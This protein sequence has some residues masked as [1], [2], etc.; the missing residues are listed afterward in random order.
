MAFYPGSELSNDATN[1][2]GPNPAAVTAMLKT[3][4][5]PRGDVVAGA[6]ALP[7]RLAKAAYYRARYGH[8]F[9][10]ALRADRMVAHAR[11]E[12]V[13]PAGIMVRTGGETTVRTR[14]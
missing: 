2:C 3:V 9:V 5:L 14:P 13:H 11:R 12:K 10:A 8:S 6:R 7:F 4:G 1:W